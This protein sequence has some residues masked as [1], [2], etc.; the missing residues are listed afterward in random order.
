MESQDS[1]TTDEAHGRRQRRPSWPSRV[2]LK[3]L[4][5]LKSYRKKGESAEYRK[6]RRERLTIG[7]LLLTTIFT[8]I[9][10]VIFYF[11]L[12]EMEKVYP[13]IKESADAS[14]ISQSP[15]LFVSTPT[16]VPGIP[17]YPTI[18]FS[19]KNYGRTPA[20]LRFYTGRIYIPEQLPQA[21]GSSPA[22]SVWE[23]IKPDDSYKGRPVEFFQKFELSEFDKK[24]P[25]LWFEVSY[26]D[27]FGYVHTSGF[28]F[29]LYAVETKGITISPLGGGKYSYHHKEKMPENEWTP[30]PGRP[31]N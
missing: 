24:T 10:A 30:K 28:T 4:N 18:D 22:G 11:Q 3:P 14:V 2:A 19:F 25:L 13:P 15:Y 27:L 1:S 8:F 17:G 21:L 23:V 26:A 9:T 31:P 29:S 5:A 20:I 7:L 16:L 6:E 12:R